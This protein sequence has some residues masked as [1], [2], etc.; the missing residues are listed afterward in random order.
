MIN[1][2]LLISKIKQSKV[3]NKLVIGNVSYS[4]TCIQQTP[5]IERTL[6]RVLRVSA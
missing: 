5:L 1:L 6:A 3:K 4:E 2:I